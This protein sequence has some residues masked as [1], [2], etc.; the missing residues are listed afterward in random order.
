MALSRKPL[1]GMRELF[2]QE[3]RV[4]DYIVGQLRKA[5]LAYGFETYEAPVLEPLDLFLAKSGS[6]LAIDQSYNFTDKGGRKLILR[7]ELTPSL[8]RMVAAAGELI[9][10]VKWMSFPLCYR[11]ENTQRGRAREFLQFN[12][13]I[14][15]ADDLEAELEMFLVLQRIMDGF[16]AVP[17]QYAIRYSSRTLASGVLG[18]C[19]FSA[20]EMQK[21][22][23]VIDKKDRMPLEKWEKWLEDEIPDSSKAEAIINFASCGTLKSSWLSQLMAED[24]AY[25][26]LVKFGG[27]LDRAGVASAS[28]EAGVVRGLDYYTGIVFEVMDTG[29]ENRRAI[30]GGGRYDNLVGMFS[31]QNVSGV[32][33][34]LGILT[35]KLFLQTYGLIPD[36]LALSHPADIFLAVCTDEQREFALNLAERLRDADVTVEMDLSR[37]NLSK[38]FKIA[39]RKAIRHVIVIGPDEVDSGHVTIRDMK[40]GESMEIDIPQIGEALKRKGN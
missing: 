15:G 29:G 20:D 24:P 5:G 14:L 23:A 13:D 6:E 19:G 17:G 10:P 31:N 25:L 11:Y 22:F 2:P 28:F 33:F 36:D 39:D 7:P 1:K 27:M 8:A 38:Q 40:T 35:L 12:L 26:E 37:K 30:C 3:K 34:G 21:A 18:R 9:F 32:G 4:E 16:S